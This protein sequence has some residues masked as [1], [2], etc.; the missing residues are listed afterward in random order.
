[1]DKTLHYYK[2]FELL[3]NHLRDKLQGFASLLPVEI[4]P[5]KIDPQIIQMCDFPQYVF[6]LNKSWE[7]EQNKYIVV[8]TP[9]PFK[10]ALPI[11]E[12]F[13]RLMINSKRYYSQCLCNIWWWLSEP[14]F[15]KVSCS[16]YIIFEPKSSLI[17]LLWLWSK[18]T[19][20]K[21]VK[22]MDELVDVGTD[23]PAWQ[24]YRLKIMSLSQQVSKVN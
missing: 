8:T 20:I 11:T 1:M 6:R 23:T 2:Y 24:R 10:D 13:I 5:I 19:T 9:S 15:Q 12:M 7:Q 17:W 16:S 3:V 4:K 22:Q 14:L 18:V 21:T